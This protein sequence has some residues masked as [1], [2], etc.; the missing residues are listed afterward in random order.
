VFAADQ[1]LSLIAVDVRTR[2]K[3]WEMY[4]DLPDVASPLAAG[5]LVVAAASYGVVTCLEAATGTVLWRQEFET[6]FY[7]S[8]VLAGGRL[9]LLDRSGVMRILAADRGP[10]LL[11]SPAIGEPADATPAFR[12]GII[13]IRGNRH[14]FCIE[15]SGG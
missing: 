9:Y 8:P 13:F 1:L 14:L 3:R 2:A 6:G 11:G 15:A 5:E 4:D 7:A 12:A 10:Q